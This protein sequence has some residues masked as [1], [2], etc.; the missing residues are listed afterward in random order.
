[1]FD[2][3]FVYDNVSMNLST[4]SEDFY[5]IIILPKLL[6]DPESGI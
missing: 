6:C 2:V 1:M 4:S 5:E 3:M